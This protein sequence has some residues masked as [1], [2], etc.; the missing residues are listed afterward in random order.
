L[1]S[2]EGT[3][4]LIEEKF[5]R[6][7]G[8]AVDVEVMA[9]ATLHEGRPAVMVLFRD[10]TRRKQ[11]EEAL[12]KS[13]SHLRLISENMVDLITQIDKDRKVIY[14]S[15]SLER[16]TGYT[17]ADLSGHMVTEYI[18]PDDRERVIR[19]TLAAI[20]S[21]KPSFRLEYRYREK[22]GEYRW[23][24]SETRILRDDKEEFNGAIFTSRDI[25][26]RKQ[27]ENDLQE[28]T[29][30]LDQY[31]T[32][33]LDL[34]C[35]ADT[36]GFFRRLNPEWEK[37]LGYTLEE[38]EGHR[39]LDFVHPDDLHATQATA[40]E[41]A[42]QN[43]VLNFT[44]RYRHKD[45]TYRWIEW[46]SF[47]KGN[48]IYAAA[49][50]ITE[51]RNMEDAI[52]GA[53]RKLNLLNSITRHDVANQL[54]ILQGYTGIAVTKNTDP[55]IAD[56]LARIEASSLAIARQIEFTRTYQELG[57]HSPAWFRLDQ[58]VVKEGNLVVTFSDS[59]K[60]AD[61]FA[62]PMLERVFFNL[63][64]NAVRHGERVTGVTFR[65]R[66][67]QNGLVIIVED[68]GVGIPENE[69]EKIFMRGYGKNTGF[70]LFLAREI[71]AITG[72]TIRETGIAGEGARFEI[73]VPNG[74]YRFS[75]T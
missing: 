49:R 23:F 47:P 40:A 74:G 39:F 26:E 67:D 55:V 72:I 3:V 33:S 35:I 30:E 6:I 31:F 34:F 65:C 5:V 52:R 63:L 11:I 17:P 27:I 22:N 21:H 43:E 9:T 53:N 66:Q 10:I 19:V 24:E 62:D 15:P 45:G 51:R 57:I 54:T 37:A 73:T 48:R 1:Q 58:I 59:C 36:D 44:N 61:I 69:K 28:K 18:H 8:T 4:P 64:D 25:T 46:R 70:G 12:Q 75:D 20:E 16:L 56:F 13:E 42:G 68:N 29:E 2:P 7:D 41:L 71:L 50:D 60:H 32:T 38:L 14:V